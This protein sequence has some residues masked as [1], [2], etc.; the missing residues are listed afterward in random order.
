MNTAQITNDYFAVLFPGGVDAVESAANME[1]AQAQESARVAAVKAAMIAA[2]SAKLA[3]RC[4]RCMG[5][6]KLAQFTH[7]AGGVCFACG[8]SG[9]FSRFA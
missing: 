5:S 3:A 4:N 6:G 9:L 7:R 8:G 1:A 2:E